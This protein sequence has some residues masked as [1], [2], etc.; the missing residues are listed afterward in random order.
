MKHKRIIY[1]VTFTVAF[2]SIVY[3]LLLAQALSAFLDNTV[4]R[5]SVTIGLYMFSMGLG[6][7]IAEGRLSRHA[8]FSLLLI[9]IS[10][11]LIGGGA[12]VWLYGADMLELSRPV[13]SLFAHILIVVIG[14]L[15]GF[16]IP[17][18]IELAN[19]R[20]AG[21][22]ARVIAVDYAGAF[23]GTLLFAFVFY[24]VIGLVPTAF[25]IGSLNA[26]AG[27]C[28]GTQTDLLPAATE[29][30][31]RAALCLQGAL[32]LVIGMCLAAS[33]PISSLFINQ[34][35]SG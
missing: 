15:T 13:F 1:G 21:S 19:H 25:L 31:F 29:G 34:Y 27:L 23:A 14:I 33:G 10:L 9:E 16:E 22:E 4:L 6:A 8:L 28:L 2:C 26:V 17:L 30:R 12:I 32:F 20:E 7:F 18:L 24:P 5:Y 11:S 35:L 3:E